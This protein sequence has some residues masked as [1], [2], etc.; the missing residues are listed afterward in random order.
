MNVSRMINLQLNEIA[1]RGADSRIVYVTATN[2]PEAFALTG[3]YEV[4]ENSLTV[5]VNVKQNKEIKYRF[6]LSGTK[7]KLKE[8]AADI[9]Q[10]AA[11]WV[12]EIK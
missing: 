2:S 8:L 10:K 11:V 4:K 5:K 12:A 3:R 6:E 9:S 1:A 7:D